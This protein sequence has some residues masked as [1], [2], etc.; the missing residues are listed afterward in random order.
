M[1]SH[2]FSL[3]NSSVLITGASSGLGLE[4]ARQL[5]SQVAILILVARRGQVLEELKKEL[6]LKNPSLV[7][8]VKSLDLSRAQEREQ[9]AAWIKENGVPLH[10][11]INNAGVGDLGDFEHATWERLQPILDINITALTHLTHLLLPMLR[12]HAPSVL[13]Q[14]GS[15]AGFFSLPYNAVYAA[16][17]AYVKSFSESLAVEEQKNG[18]LVTLLAPGPVPTPFFEIANRPGKQIEAASRLPQPF[19]SSAEEVVASALNGILKRC[20]C[21]IPN[22]N[23]RIAVKLCSMLPRQIFKFFFSFTKSSP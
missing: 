3:K 4:F 22:Q 5:A 6:M 11:L 9:L 16:S 21:V 13:L 8:H 1:N 15:V 7:L 19:V 23:L 17:K 18:V 12:L 20:E 10:V 14:V 2:S